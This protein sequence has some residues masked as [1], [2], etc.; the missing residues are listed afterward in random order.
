MSQFC[1]SA[2]TSV[3]AR[4]T[5]VAFPSSILTAIFTRW[6]LH[7]G[8]VIKPFGMRSCGVKEGR[9]LERLEQ[10]IQS[11]WLRVFEDCGDADCR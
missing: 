1:T 10:P 4:S 5:A 7:L 8:I 6:P 2:Y 9:S 3:G 11:S